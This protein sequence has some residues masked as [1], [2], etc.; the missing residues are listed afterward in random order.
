MSKSEGGLYIYQSVNKMSLY[1]KYSPKTLWMSTLKLVRA[2]FH[3]PPNLPVEPAS[4]FSEVIRAHKWIEND[5]AGHF[6]NVVITINTNTTIE[7]IHTC[8]QNLSKTL[9]DCHFEYPITIKGC[10][11]YTEAITS[12]LDD[13]HYC[14][15]S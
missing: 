15:L 6:E 10:Q 7:Q 1:T 8:L 4:F 12:K 5:L 13:S 11:L 14:T 2:F 9:F 3:T